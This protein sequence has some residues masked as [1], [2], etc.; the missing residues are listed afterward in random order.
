M[1]L[2]KLA[3]GLALITFGVRFLRKGLDRLFGGRLLVFLERASS[4]RLK[5]LCAGI[6]TGAAAP[7]STGLSLLLAQILGSGRIGTDRLLTILLGANIGTTVLANVA[8]LELGDYAGLLLFLGV[9]G[10]QFLRKERIRGIGQCLLAL[11]FI[12]L[13]MDVLKEGA[14]TF[15][16][17]KDVD[18]IFA[19]LDRHPLILC[20]AAAGLAVLLQ[21]STATVGLGIGLA[22]GGVLPDS[23][24]W[25]WIIGTNIGLG[26]TSLF[27]SSGSLEGKR[28]GIANV[29][30][31]LVVAAL[32]A[33]LSPLA[34]WGVKLSLPVGQRLALMHTVFNVLVALISLPLVS[35]LLAAVRTVFVPNRPSAEIQGSFL[36]PQALESAS[37]A[38]AHATRESL[39]MTDTVRTMLQNLWTA[40]LQGDTA[41]IKSARTQDDEVDEMHRELM[42]F[43]SQIGDLSDFDRKWHS[44]LMSYTSELEGVGDILE[45]NLSATMLRQAIDGVSLPSTDMEILG[46]L[47]KN[48]MLRFELVTG[49]V[50]T[51]ETATA[52]RIA[53]AMEE[54][55][56][57]CSNEKRLHYERLRSADKHG[58]AISLC[59][60]DILDG[61]RRVSDHLS[62]IA[63]AFNSPTKRSRKVRAKTSSKAFHGEKALASEKP[64]LNLNSVSTP[65]TVSGPAGKNQIPREP[66]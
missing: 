45:K 29:G 16:N 23:L 42:L 35:L 7:S 60:F 24:F 18:A 54:M 46:K 22:A 14:A 33:C 40:Y 66:T 32:I 61:L 55:D 63:V 17:S 15:G 49:W 62:T 1:F 31:K 44:I 12:F 10:F 34:T 3:A 57:W 50:T 58:L 21:S 59:F 26:L 41:G 9:V 2:L 65:E 28:L 4:N 36:N 5:A 11:G 51:R 30:S 47:Y 19:V 48:T 64:A 6:V 37:I 20:V 56:D 52:E 27:V 13:A 25:T 8:A 43:L 38:L 39:R 53:V